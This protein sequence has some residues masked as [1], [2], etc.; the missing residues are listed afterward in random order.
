MESSFPDSYIESPSSEFP[1]RVKSSLSLESAAT[2][3]S[4]FTL[5]SSKRPAPSPSTMAMLFRLSPL[6]SMAAVSLLAE[7][8]PNVDANMRMKIMKHKFLIFFIIKPT[9][10]FLQIQNFS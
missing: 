10:N 7:A 6:E 3:L 1:R 4:K 9:I 5:E 2:S 8:N